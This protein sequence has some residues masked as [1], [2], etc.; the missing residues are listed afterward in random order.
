M[1]LKNKTI[2][3]TGTT[4][5]IGAALVNELINYDCKI[6]S[7]SRNS[8]KLFRQKKSAPGKIETFVCDFTNFDEI[9]NI[10]SEIK[11]NYGI[12]D[13]VVLNAGIANKSSIENFDLS[14]NLKIIN[15]NLSANVVFCNLLLPDFINRN[16]GIIAGVSSLADNRAYSLSSLYSA[17]KSALSIFFEGLAIEAE[18]YNFTISTIRPGFVK[19]QITDKNEFHMPFL[20]DGNKAAKIIVKGLIKEKRYIQFPFM[21]YFLTRIFRFIPNNIFEKL[22]SKTIPDKK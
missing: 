3:I 11:S 2:L 1:N 9:K 22:F 17:S 13:V 5:G 6:I 8:E 16:S 20:M 14:E 10:Y 21:T 18:K 4:S 19:S 15:T 12:P 7:V